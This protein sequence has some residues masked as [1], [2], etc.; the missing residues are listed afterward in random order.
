MSSSSR[1]GSEPSLAGFLIAA[2]NAMEMIE[3][4][5]EV[6]IFQ[7]SRELR[8]IEWSSHVRSGLFR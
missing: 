7:I 3:N 8:K 2:W 1:M 4:Y 5:N 6:D